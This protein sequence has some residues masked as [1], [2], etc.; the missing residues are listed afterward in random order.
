MER[1]KVVYL[2]E[3][4]KVRQ[5]KSLLEMIEGHLAEARLLGKSTSICCR[6]SQGLEECFQLCA[7]DGDNGKTND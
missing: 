2:D 5:Y 7:E 6:S 4:R 3:Y 1:A